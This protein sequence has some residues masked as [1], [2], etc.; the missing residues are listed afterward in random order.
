MSAFLL[1]FAVTLSQPRVL[2]AAGS[3]G[4][5]LQWAVTVVTVRNAGSSA[6]YPKAAGEEVYLKF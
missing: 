3:G 1:R 6:K 5:F 2:N 4:G